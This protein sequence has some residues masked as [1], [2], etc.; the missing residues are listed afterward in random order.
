MPLNK[1]LILKSIKPSGCLDNIISK[2]LIKNP[3]R[4]LFAK[5]DATISNKLLSADKSNN[6]VDAG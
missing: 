3:N 2:F 6:T 1:S 5:Y 4:S